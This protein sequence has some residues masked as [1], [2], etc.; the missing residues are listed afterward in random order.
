MRLYQ[1]TEDGVD[2]TSE[3]RNLIY[4]QQLRCLLNVSPGKASAVILIYVINQET[5]CDKEFVSELIG[6]SDNL[7]HRE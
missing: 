6:I 7:V 3:F 2:E 5:G 1:V 4:L